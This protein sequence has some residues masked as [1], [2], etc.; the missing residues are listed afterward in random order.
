MK[1]KE[2]LN[3]GITRG[4]DRSK[5]DVAERV[6]APEPIVEVTERKSEVVRIG[7]SMPS[8]D[9]AVLK[10]LE[11]RVRPLKLSAK[12]TTVSDL[13]RA[14]IYALSGLPDKDLVSIISR[15]EHIKPGRKK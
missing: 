11:A 7:A 9:R 5:A 15:L 10:A 4:D 2:Q 12:T 8:S 6:A 1:T 14:G 3:E 13:I